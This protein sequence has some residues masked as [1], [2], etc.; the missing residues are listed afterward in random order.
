MSDRTP[1]YSP[2]QVRAVIRLEV[3]SLIS[4]VTSRPVGHTDGLGAERDRRVKA[5]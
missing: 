5:V 3:A 2:E 4:H 1:H